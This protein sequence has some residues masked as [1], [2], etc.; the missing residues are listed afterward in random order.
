[1]EDDLNFLTLEDNLIFS[2]QIRKIEDNLMFLEKEGRPK[3]WEKGRQSA[4]NIFNHRSHVVMSAFVL[5]YRLLLSVHSWVGT[6]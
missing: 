2:K 6:Y 5:C 3:F 1:M 4:Q